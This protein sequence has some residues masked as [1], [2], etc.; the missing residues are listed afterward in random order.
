MSSTNPDNT[1]TNAEVEH[2]DRLEAIV[3]RGLDADLQLGN[4]LAEISDA[5]LYRGVHQTFDAYLRDRWGISRAPGNQL[6]QSAELADP[7]STEV[8][9][10]APATEPEER[11]VAPVRGEGPEALA[12]LWEQ[13]FR[14]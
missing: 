10:P 8:V 1:L 6:I 7:S 5:S 13:A 12:D 2:L 11:P 14:N 9:V 4:A 3:Q